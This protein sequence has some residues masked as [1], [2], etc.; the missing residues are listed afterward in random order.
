MIGYF[1]QNIFFL[2]PLFQF[3]HSY[4]SLG[5][6]F[7]EKVLPTPVASPSLLLYNANLAIELGLNQMLEESELAKILSGNELAEGASPI[8]QA[9]AG[10]QFGYFAKLGD[11]RAILLGEHI[12]RDGQRW[13]IQLKG[14]GPT[15]YSRRGDGRAT[16][17]AM[18][19]EYLISEAMNGLGIPSSR[20]LAVVTTGEKVFREEIQAGAVLT[21]VMKS[22]IRVGTFEYA[23]Q[24]LSTQELDSL[25]RYT[26]ERH[27]PEVSI[28]ENAA[29]TLL[30][31]VLQ[32]QAHLV[33]QWM[34]VG[35][36]HGVMNTDNMSIAGE[37]F[38]YGPCAF[39]NSY[40]P[41][42]AFSSIDTNGRYAFGNQPNIAHWNLSCLANALLPIID[43]DTDTAVKKATEV[44]NQFP[45]L[46]TQ[47]YTATMAAKIG[48]DDNSISNEVINLLKEL[49]QWMQAEQADYTN[50]FLT[51][52]GLLMP[53]D[54][55][56]SEA[57]TAW[58]RKHE[59]LL[60]KAGMRN[61]VAVV[62][63]LGISKTKAMA[64]MQQNNPVV[65]PRN[66]RVEEALDAVVNNHD[67]T[68]FNQLLQLLQQ[69]YNV[70]ADCKA[71][72][73]PPENGDGF[74]ATY[75]GT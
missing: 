25:T 52:Q 72:Q 13:D 33:A 63:V 69:P 5:N 56:A 50:T 66:H 17:R 11:G 45:S 10:H 7:F 64:L 22:H 16:L 36:I 57:F 31:Q 20:S 48:F 38:D 12:S 58:M 27:Y 65:I 19:R 73:N 53:V 71:Y 8:A 18:L 49:M 44:L 55:Y 51:I 29:L 40:D 70:A 67:L 15:P 30:E 54:K 43:A 28:K 2:D 26:L 35:F 32:Q 34:R 61:D 42:K 60:T 6:A 4:Q 1:C 47:L 59:I 75:C 21:R 23:R 3:N 37:T 62:D 68:L 14:A 46:Y 74:Y 9:Y 24:F 41:T 39:I